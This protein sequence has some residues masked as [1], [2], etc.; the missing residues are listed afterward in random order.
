MNFAIGELLKTTQRYRELD[1][2]RSGIH[3][4]LAPVAPA[5]ATVQAVYDGCGNRLLRQITIHLPKQA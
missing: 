5:V 4:Y 1:P 2:L 3:T